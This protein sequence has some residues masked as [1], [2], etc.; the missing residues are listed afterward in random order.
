M[1]RVGSSLLKGARQALAYAKGK[2]LKAKV[3]KVMVP[4]EV[5][6][7]A[8]R[9][10]LAMNRKEFC[11]YFGF[12]LRTLE[13]WEQGLRNPEGP[14]R[15]YLMVIAYKPEIVVQALSAWH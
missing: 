2:K 11:E 15:A 4:D 14:A 7:K 9:R 12:S 5:D 8:I 6:V 10:E 1:T 3:H 13:K